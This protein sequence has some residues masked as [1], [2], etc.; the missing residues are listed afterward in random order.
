MG[1]KV[2]WDECKEV[3]RLCRDEDR[4]VKALLEL[5]LARDAKMS[6]KGFYRYLNQERK[7]REGIPS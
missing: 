2:L 4:T 1:Y 6:K 5:N 7:V 3:P